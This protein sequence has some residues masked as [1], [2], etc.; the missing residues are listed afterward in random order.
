MGEGPGVRAIYQGVAKKPTMQIMAYLGKQSKSF[1][2]G[3]GFFGIILLAAHLHG[4]LV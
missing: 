1:L 3:L 4:G 2:I